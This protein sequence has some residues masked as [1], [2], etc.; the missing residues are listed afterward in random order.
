MGGRVRWERAAARRTFALVRSARP[1]DRSELRLK[2]LQ[3][4]V[5][6]L[7]R[8]ESRRFVS[9]LLRSWAR[10]TSRGVQL[11]PRLPTPPLSP[12]VLPFVTLLRTAGNLGTTL[13]CSSRPTLC[14][15][16][17]PHSRTGMSASPSSLFSL[18][19]GPFSA[20]PHSSPSS[21]RSQPLTS[22]L[23]P[24]RPL[25]P[26]DP[27]P[28]SLRPPQIKGFHLLPALLPQPLQSLLLSQIAQ[29]DLFLGGQR[30]QVMLFGHEPLAFLK[31][32]LEEVKRWGGGVVKEEEQKDVW[33]RCWAEGDLKRQGTPL[34]V[35]AR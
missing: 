29:S 19:S 2:K 28:A 10:L 13:W 32:A 11:Q 8:P 3:P 20:S 18:D 34:H 30:D 33:E 31:T 35:L 21:S 24:P 22:P 27:T 4:Y 16:P 6:H 12:A 5:S 7:K 17:D 15:A 1:F 23:S 25:P 9:R 26:L 14:L